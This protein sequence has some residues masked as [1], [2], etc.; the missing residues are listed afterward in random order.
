MGCCGFIKRAL[1]RC[2]RKCLSTS[3]KK[4]A[5]APSGFLKERDGKHGDEI[6]TSLAI[7]RSRFVH[8]DKSEGY[9]NDGPVSVAKFELGEKDEPKKREA[10]A[11]RQRQATDVIDRV[12]AQIG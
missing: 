1:K 8:D 2:D 3:G 5:D 4:G 11:L 12:L 9:R 6:Q 7:L 10:S